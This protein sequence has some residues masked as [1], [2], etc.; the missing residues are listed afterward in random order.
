MYSV[1][2]CVWKGGGGAGFIL[3]LYAHMIKIKGFKIYAVKLSQNFPRGVLK[4]FSSK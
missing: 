2:M 1:C 4:P 3:F